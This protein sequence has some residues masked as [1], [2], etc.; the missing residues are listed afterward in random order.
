M[1]VIQKLIKS[2]GKGTKAGSKS[3]SAKK[4][5][6]EEKSRTSA[7]KQER[8]SKKVKKEPVAEDEADS[9]SRSVKMSRSEEKVLAMKEERPSKKVKREAVAEDEGN[10]TALVPPA[11]GKRRRRRSTRLLTP[12]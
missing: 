1:A 8:P 10:T 11:D 5:D 2:Q 7:V 4:H 12:S 3:K 9:K 6:T